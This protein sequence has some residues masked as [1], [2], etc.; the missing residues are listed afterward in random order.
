MDTVGTWAG[1]A[2]IAS[3]CA[4]NTDTF[5]ICKGATSKA[6]AIDGNSD[7]YSVPPC[8]TKGHSVRSWAG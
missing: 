2:V 4:K 8:G 7:S 5:K 3:V 6:A 1:D